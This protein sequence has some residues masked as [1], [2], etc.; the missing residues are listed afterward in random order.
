MGWYLG[1]GFGFYLLYS[2]FCKRAYYVPL[3]QNFSLDLPGSAL[4][5]PI[6]KYGSVLVTGFN[7]NIFDELP[8]IRFIEIQG[9]FQLLL[10][11]VAWPLMFLLVLVFILFAK[12]RG[13]N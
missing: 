3:Q 6:F 12:K 13:T 11:L 4:I 8:E 1:A 5:F 9:I 7:E 10:I 2:F